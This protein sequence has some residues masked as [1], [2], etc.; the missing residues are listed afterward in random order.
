MYVCVGVFVC[1]CV[2]VVVRCVAFISTGHA[3]AGT[4]TGLAGGSAEQP[5]LQAEGRAALEVTGRG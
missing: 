1:L 5:V 2:W 3:V 4:I